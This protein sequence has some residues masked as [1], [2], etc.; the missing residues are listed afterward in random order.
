MC[1]VIYQSHTLFTHLYPTGTPPKS[2]SSV[3]SCYICFSSS[4]TDSY[5]TW[6][7]EESKPTVS[8]CVHLNTNSAALLGLAVSPKSVN[9]TR[10]K[11]AEDMLLPKELIS[12]VIMYTQENHYAIS[13]QVKNS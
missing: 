4:Q 13:D 2:Y 8:H 3:M 12:P 7:R 9:F 1:G 6:P 11:P 10:F 5:F